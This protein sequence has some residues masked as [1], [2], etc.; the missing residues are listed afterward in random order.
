[1]EKKVLNDLHVGHY[2]DIKIQ[3]GPP[4]LELII[5][6]VGTIAEYRNLSQVSQTQTSHAIL[7]VGSHIIHCW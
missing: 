2:S 6:I 1:M 4:Y 7:S 3:N 5:I